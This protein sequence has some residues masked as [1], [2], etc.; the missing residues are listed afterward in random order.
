MMKITTNKAELKKLKACRD[1]YEKFVKA[2]GDKDAKLSECLDSNGW[3]DTWW[4]ILSTY[5][6]FTDEQKH[7]LRV[8][9]VWAAEMKKFTQELK[10]L[11]IKWE[12]QK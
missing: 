9:A 3:D 2:H 4:L 7:D 6:Q 1:G 10:E 5:E 11:F 8:S 12:I